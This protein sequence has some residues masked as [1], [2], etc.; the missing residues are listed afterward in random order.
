METRLKCFDVWVCHVIGYTAHP[1]NMVI[2]RTENLA[3]RLRPP[4]Q[5]SMVVCS[6]L[7]TEYP[8]RWGT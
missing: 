3:C 1:G 6:D 8:N 5:M 4:R 7:P 2:R